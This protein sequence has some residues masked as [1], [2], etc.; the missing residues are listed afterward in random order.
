MKFLEHDE[1]IAL[2]ETVFLPSRV[3]ILIGQEEIY[4]FQVEQ[5]AY[6]SFIK[7]LLRSYGG[8]F[9]QFVGIKESDLAKRLGIG[10]GEVLQLLRKLHAMEVVSYIEQTD[11][12]HIIFLKQRLD[13]QHLQ[14]NARYLADRH[15]INKEQV[16]SVIAYAEIRKCRSQQLLSYFNETHAKACGICDVCIEN[17]RNNKKESIIDEIIKDVLNVLSNNSLVLDDLVNSVKSG[18]DKEKLEVI[19][20]LLDAGTIKANGEYYYVS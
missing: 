8:L 9:D 18:N 10:K 19:R 13:E 4:R 14:I 15:T 17:K 2:S 7:I 3:Q 11:K 20:D 1:Y 5:P 12:P 16:K 6:D